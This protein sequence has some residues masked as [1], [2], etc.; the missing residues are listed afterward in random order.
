MIPH[1]YYT[2]NVPHTSYLHV[3]MATVLPVLLLLLALPYTAFTWFEVYYVTADDAEQSCPPHQICHNLS[4][5]IS[6]HDSHF[7][8]NNVIFLEGKHNFDKVGYVIV[9]YAHNLT[10]K[11]Q[12][13]WPVAGAEET[14][15]QSTVIINCTRGKGGFYFN[16]AHNITVEGLT[17]VNCGIK[18]HAAVFYFTAVRHIIFRKN[19]IQNITG[20]GLYVYNCDNVLI[21]NCSYYR[22]V[23]LCFIYGC[24][25]GGVG[26]EYN[27]NTSY[28][29]VLSH[30]NITKCCN[31]YNGRAAAGGISLSS[32]QAPAL[33]IQV[34][35]SHLV[36]SKNNGSG[37]K[38]DV[39]VPAMYVNI[40]NCLFSQNRA[41]YDSGGGIHIV[42][43]NADSKQ[44]NVSIL[45]TDLL[46]N[47]CP[48]SSNMHFQG[49]SSMLIEN[50]TIVDA[51]TTYSKNSVYIGP[52]L[53]PAIYSL[54]NN[55]MK[56]AKSWFLD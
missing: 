28:T 31:N 38:I 17:L 54:I 27:A 26:I 21:T 46:Q 39:N 16:S 44:I 18:D 43:S 23:V 3:L 13:Q 19:S 6:Q 45:N 29:L 33:L 52:N 37:L 34:V 12:G 22:S 24:K 42:A 53:V 51:D 36:I 30:S 10:L 7:S 1:Y 2:C 25:C 14:V 47:Y 11:G 5:Y 8:S 32:Q 41:T 48:D 35:F 40:S 49:V 9:N 50:S 56:F 55:N 4:Y 20:Y 15:M